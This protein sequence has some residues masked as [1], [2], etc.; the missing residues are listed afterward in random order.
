MESINSNQDISALGIGTG[1]I[2]F[3][4]R[5]D[6]NNFSIAMENRLDFLYM[7]NHS[8]SAQPSIH[9]HLSYTVPKAEIRFTLRT[10]YNKILRKGSLIIYEEPG[11][12]LLGGLSS[13]DEITIEINDNYYYGGDFG[14]LFHNDSYYIGPVFGLLSIKNSKTEK[15]SGLLYTILVIGKNTDLKQ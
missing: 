1:L 10:G 13:R 15:S 7:S 9:L 5:E 14:L 12:F 2:T 3:P 11:N 8:I 4:F 6:N